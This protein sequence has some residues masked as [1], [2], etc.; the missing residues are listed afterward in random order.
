M[1]GSDE[2]PEA[3]DEL[4]TLLALEGDEDGDIWSLGFGTPDVEVRTG[5]LNTVGMMPRA[6]EE[7]KSRLDDA[8]ALLLSEELQKHYMLR[9]PLTF[10]SWL[11]FSI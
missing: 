7:W 5:F 4:A 10:S 2:I 9:L 3:M 8:T 6:K 1:V 11:P